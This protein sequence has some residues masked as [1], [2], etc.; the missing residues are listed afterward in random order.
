MTP[1]LNAFG[2]TVP[3][4]KE[5]FDDPEVENAIS[6]IRLSL[7]ESLG[8]NRDESDS[9]FAECVRLAKESAND[10]EYER[11]T[12]E[13]LLSAGITT[14]VPKALSGRATIIYEQIKDY[15]AAGSVLDLGC[16]DAEVGRRLSRD[17]REVSIAD[18]YEHHNVADSGLAFNL[19]AQDGTLPY[20]DNAFDNVIV[21]TVGHHSD[22]PKKL[23]QEAYRVCK[24]GGRVI[25][26]E[27]VFGVDGRELND[28]ELSAME[29][30]FTVLSPERQRLVNVYFDHFYNR[31][32][33]YSDD[34]E[35]KVNVPY[36]F[37]TPE[38]WREIFESIGFNQFTV[39]HLGKDQEIVPEYHT[40]HVLKKL[41]H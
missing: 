26:I 36:N 29:T 40:L 30:A 22:D 17:G 39:K 37:N 11:K 14:R 35:K 28:R 41:A 9:V 31:I 16:G 2:H 23:F 1:E 21:L 15:L 24:Q 8:I 13:L 38:G 4:I 18:V 32:L 25:V 33:H 27:S 6:A 19:L 3:E 5:V 7:F 12:H 10:A 20:E 34:P